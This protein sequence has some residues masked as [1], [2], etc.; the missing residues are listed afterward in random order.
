MLNLRK[1]CV[2]SIQYASAAITMSLD[3]LTHEPPPAIL[4]DKE[5]ATDMTALT[6]LQKTFD[7]LA[8]EGKDIDAA[9]VAEAKLRVK[10]ADL[11]ISRIRPSRPRSGSCARGP[12]RRA[13]S[14]PRPARFRTR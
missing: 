14:W 4:R 9:S 7:A 11:R 8:L 1:V 6:R 2:V 10:S 12:I 5:F 13:A 3:D